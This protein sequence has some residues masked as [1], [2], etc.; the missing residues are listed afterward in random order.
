MK[1]I[2]DELEIPPQD[3]TDPNYLT[4][5]IRSALER[6]VAAL[7]DR[8]ARQHSLGRRRAATLVLARLRGLEQS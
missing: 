6:E 3:G 1:P 2:D 7:V 4:Q 8:V 5:D